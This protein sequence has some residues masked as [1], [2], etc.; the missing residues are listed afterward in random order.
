MRRFRTIVLVVITLSASVSVRGDDIYTLI[1]EGK[2]HE[3]ADSLSQQS[4]AALRDGRLLFLQSLIE[5]DADEAA[6][7]M[8]AALNTSV[9]SLYREEIYL[10]LAQYYLMKQDYR[11]LS[12]FVNEYRARWETGRYEAEMMRL[13]VLLAEIEKDYDAALKQADRYLLRFTDGE[14]KQWGEIDKA[15]V[16]WAHDKDIGAVKMLRGLAREKSG[17]GVAPA[18]YLLGIDAVRKTRTDDAVFY[19]NLLRDGY[20]RSVGLDHLMERLG[21][22]STSSDDQRA[23]EITGTYYSVKVGVFSSND[24]ARRFA[25][26]FRSYDKKIDITSKTIS[27]KKYRVVY[28]GRFS[29]FDDAMKFKSQLESAHDEVFQVVAR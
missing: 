16:L 8:E 3:A 6:R 21:A 20:P 13:A 12:R 2:L 17:P 22:M 4:S 7:L 1:R 27:G 14:Q 23:E 29:R 28:V 10:R 24:N 11:R 19:Y 5:P 15:R 18:L 26:K 25:E 9:P